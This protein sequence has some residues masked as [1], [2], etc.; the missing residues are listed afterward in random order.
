MLT[1][2]SMW[3]ARIAGAIGALLALGACS[4][5]GEAAERP[6]TTT[7][8]VANQVI[9]L[10]HTHLAVA[11]ELGYFGETPVDYL[12]ADGT[13]AATQAVATGGADFAQSDTQALATA[14]SKGVDNLT[15]ICA[16][17]PNN[18]YQV[19]VPE[20]SDIQSPADLAGKRIGLG[21]LGTGTYYNARLALG[22]VGLEE[23]DVEFVTIGSQ[24]GQL[25]ALQGGQVDALSA[26]DVTIGTFANQG[27]QLRSLPQDGAS[28]WQWNI[29]IGRSDAIESD[30]DRAADVCRGIQQA[31][32]LV[33]ESPEAAFTL[34][35]D[36]GG[37]V[38]A[39]TPDEGRNIIT[40]RS[41]AGFTT[42]PEGADKW[43][44]LNID[45]MDTLAAS[46]R[47]L[48]LFEE[49]VAVA[50]AYSNA[51]LDQIQPD[52]E[53]VQADIEKVTE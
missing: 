45:E 4:N 43:G 5:T 10:G 16:Y 40:A 9:N 19:V 13:V 36:W 12:T 8:M 14:L 23:D 24:A 52:T 1:A 25:Q 53:Q 37:D 39:L 21:S 30:P 18:I 48:G 50:S 2:K 51:L 29:V 22:S 31:Q 32:H 17:V 42:Y 47:D 11:Q 3:R 34:F 27:A 26:I 49:E 15:A 6:D 28:E 33:K 7:F 38:G 46:Y 41:E 20:D 35:Q 44:W